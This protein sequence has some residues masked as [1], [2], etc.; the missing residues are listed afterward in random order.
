MNFLDELKSNFNAAIAEAKQSAG[1]TIYNAVGKSLT[2]EASNAGIEL[3]S[4]FVPKIEKSDVKSAT[5]VFSLSPEMMLA[6]GVAV[7]SLFFIFKSK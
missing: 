2:N 6:A 1:N 3:K 7:V 4:Q 5:S